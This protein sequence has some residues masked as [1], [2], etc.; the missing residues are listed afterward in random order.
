[1]NSYTMKE[2]PNSLDCFIGQDLYE[3]QMDVTGF[4]FEALDGETLSVGNSS[5]ATLTVPV[6]ALYAKFQVT[7]TNE[8][9]YTTDGTTPAPGSG[10]GIEVVAGASVYVIYGNALNTIKF[11]C[12]S[13]ETS[14]LYVEY[15]D[16]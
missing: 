15:F 4:T 8:V 2:M 11:I 9:H 14:T 10:T 1:M 5:A 12:S 13:G 3:R 6:T 16:R 7:G